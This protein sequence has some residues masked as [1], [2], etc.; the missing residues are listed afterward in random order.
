MTEDEL[1]RWTE[2]HREITRS[3]QLDRCILSGQPVD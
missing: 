1:H 3:T 2:A